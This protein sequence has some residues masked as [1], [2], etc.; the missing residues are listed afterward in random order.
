VLGIGTLLGVMALTADLIGVGAYPGFGWKQAL[1]TV[2]ALVLVGA[3]SARIV[4][5]ERR[6]TANE[7]H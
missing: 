1:A 4:R 7:R 2:V 3:S 5:R 6:R